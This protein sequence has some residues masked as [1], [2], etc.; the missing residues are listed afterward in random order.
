MMR[1][2]IRWPQYALTPGRLLISACARAVK[3]VNLKVQD[4]QRDETVPI[5]LESAV[6]A[7]W[8]ARGRGE[9][10]PAAYSGQLELDNAYRI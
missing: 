1:N 3:R 8:A 9:F 6:D 2:A 10:F 7:F 5:N 4:D